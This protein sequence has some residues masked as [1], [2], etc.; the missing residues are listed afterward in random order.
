MLGHWSCLGPG[1]EKKWYGTHECKPDGQWDEVA[2]NMMI[3]F[4]ESG[5]LFFR[6]SSASERGE[7]KSKGKGMNTIH[8]NGS[9][10]TIE[11]IL[12]TAISVNQ[13]SFYGAERLSQ[14]LKRYGETGMVIPTEFATAN[15][16]PQTDAEVQGNL[17]REY[18]QTLAAL[19]EQT[20]LTKLCSNAGF[21]RNIEKGQFF[22]TLDDDTHDKLMGSC[23]EYT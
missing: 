1:S 18:E 9:D 17:F 12:R 15:Q 10:E 2:E 13:L 6:A 22:N 11:L 21:S 5:H 20:K 3:N 8:F 23:R 14:R 7:L 4:A 19:P 16:I